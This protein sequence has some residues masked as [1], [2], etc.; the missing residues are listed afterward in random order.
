LLQGKEVNVIAGVAAC[1]VGAM[2]LLL[3]LVIVYINKQTHGMTDRITKLLN[4][5]Q[6][7]LH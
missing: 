7:S 1:A 4:L 6:C 2:M 3:L 5:L